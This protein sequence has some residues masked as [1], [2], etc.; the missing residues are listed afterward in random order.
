MDMNVAWQPFKERDS[1]RLGSVIRDTTGA[2]MATYSEEI[3]Q[4]G[5]DL[6]MATISLLKALSFCQDVGFRQ[7]LVEFNHAP[8]KALR[9]S[10]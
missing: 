2:L 4:A 7:V 6:Y 10:I 3:P 1:W 5:D 9:V 8:L